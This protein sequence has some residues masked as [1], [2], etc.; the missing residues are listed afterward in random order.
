MLKNENHA[1]PSCLYLMEFDLIFIPPP[2][3]FPRIAH[4]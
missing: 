4:F 2:Q 1:T 3:A